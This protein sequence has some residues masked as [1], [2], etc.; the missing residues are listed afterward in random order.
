MMKYIF[1]LL[2]GL[3]ILLAGCN[4]GRSFQEIVGI[5]YVNINCSE[6][7]CSCVINDYCDKLCDKYVLRPDRD[8]DRVEFNDGV[9]CVCS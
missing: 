7:D 6:I 9:R 3:S 2:V 5:V 8:W 4:D 1:L